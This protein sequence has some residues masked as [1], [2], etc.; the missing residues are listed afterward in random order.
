V[1]QEYTKRSE[2]CEQFAGTVHRFFSFIFF[3]VLHGMPGRT[4]DEKGVRLSVRP[5]VKRVDC[6]KKK[7]K[8]DLSRFLYNMKGHLT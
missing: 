6:E 3:C 1:I 8:K 4:S 5:S 7:R 2:L